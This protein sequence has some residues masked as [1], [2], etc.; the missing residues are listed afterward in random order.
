MNPYLNIHRPCG[1]A[2]GTLDTR[3][4]RQGRYPAEDYQTPYEKLRSLDPA[5]DLK[6]QLSGA[7]LDR[8][9]AEIGDTECARR[10][11]A[12]KSKLLR[13]CKVEAP[14]PPQFR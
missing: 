2:T 9:V 13:Q 11:S 7:Q 10:M 1:F 5:V 4:K 14:L 6:P 8:T 3:G 12:A